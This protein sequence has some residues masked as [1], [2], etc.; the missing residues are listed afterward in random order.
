VLLQQ[1]MMG[2]S[3][4]HAE[5]FTERGEVHQLANRLM[6]AQA[7]HEGLASTSSSVLVNAR[8]MFVHQ[9][10]GESIASKVLTCTNC[11]ACK[12]CCKQPTALTHPLLH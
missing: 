1:L 8:R 4:K 7:V 10:V 6:L 2:K 9:M 12:D 11:S 5:V 3:L